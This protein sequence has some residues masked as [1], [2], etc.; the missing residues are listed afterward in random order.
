MRTKRGG[1][2]LIELLATMVIISLAMVSVST[3]FIGGTISVA[4]AKRITAATNRAQQEMERLRSA[5][6][7]GCLIDPDVFP[8]ASGYT[9]VQQYSDLTGRVG[10]TPSDL[11]GAT[12]YIDISYY[13]SGAGIYPNLKTVA[14]TI[15]WTGGKPTRGQVQLQTFIAN[16]P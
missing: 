10:F 13:D 11:P 9:I 7:A 2:S 3:L 15:T 6:F 4:K 5:G 12:G 14:I 16:H 1:F 8:S